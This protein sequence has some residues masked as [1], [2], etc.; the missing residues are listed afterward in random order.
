MDHAADDHRLKM[1]RS[2]WR[3]AEAKIYPM[4]MVD[5][6]SYQRAV[7]AV[8]A[9]IGDLRIDV[10]DL[11][12]L[13]QRSLDPPATLLRWAA[14]VDTGLLATDLVDAACAAR[15]REIATGD[16]LRRRAVAI[17]DGAARG[18][19]WVSV[20]P[21]PSEWA[22]GAR[23]AVPELVVHVPSALAIYTDI[24][25][26]PDTGAPAYFV[27]AVHVDLAS[28]AVLGEASALGEAQLVPDV[29]A[30]ENRRARLAFLIE[31]AS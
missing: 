14:G 5:A 28:G 17:A 10:H 19:P 29:Q 8:A 9:M 30:W 26:D 2:R 3:A 16:Q 6:E 21:A 12:D 18:E 24:G 13:V 1:L 23:Q 25:V 7:T 31:S 11:D 15:E 4:A 20:A 27:V 22:S